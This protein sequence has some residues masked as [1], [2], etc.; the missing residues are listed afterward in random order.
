MGMQ[1]LSL[2]L[3][4]AAD[5][6]WNPGLDDAGPFRAADPQGFFSR[7]VDGVTVSAISVVNHSPDFSFLG[8][9]LCRP[10]W[11]GQ[12]HGMAI[13]RHALLHAGAR[14]VG[15]DGVLQHV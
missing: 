5:K 6:A 12:G 8:F 3:D 7:R 2:T 14:T 4:W 1:D 9:Y 11:R 10:E 13:W 15:L